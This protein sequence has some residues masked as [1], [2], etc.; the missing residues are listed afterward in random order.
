MYL[1]NTHICSLFLEVLAYNVPYKKGIESLYLSKDMDL[2]KR[3]QRRDTKIA[4]GMEHLSY[5][6]KL[7]ELGLF[8]WRSEDWSDFIMALQ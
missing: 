2:F 8:A 3:V 1:S 7:R 6:S 5:E 4:R